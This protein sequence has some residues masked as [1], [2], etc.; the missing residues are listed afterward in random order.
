[1][2]NN[3]NSSED[4][5]A[6]STPGRD[7]VTRVLGD[8]DVGAFRLSFGQERLWFLD[9]LV[10]GSSTYNIT[11]GLRLKGSLDVAALEK[12]FSELVRRHEA[13]RTR[14]AAIDGQPL[15]VV[16]APAPW[17]LETTDLR[18]LGDAERE[19]EAQRLARVEA[20]RPFDLSQGPLLRTLL[21][22]LGP[23]EHL[24]LLAI[25]HIVSDGWSMGVLLNELAAC[26]G[27]FASGR[28]P[29][30]R[31]LPIQYADYAA[32][33]REQLDAEALER[34]L[35]YWREQ[36]DGAPVPMLPTDRAEED[37]SLS[38]LATRCVR[39]GADLTAKLRD[40]SRRERVTLFMTLLSAFTTLL[41]RYTG[42]NDILVS[43]SIADRNRPETED[44]IGVLINVLLLRT[45]LSGNPTFS[46]VLASV[47]DV[48]LGAFAHQNVPFEKVVEA[49]RL[50]RK[51][52]RLAH[53]RVSF[54]LQS[55]MAEMPR[56]PHL[57]V[58]P[59]KP[60][61]SAPAKVDLTLFAVELPGELVLS[62]EYN[63]SLFEP[64]TI[65]NMC[66]HLASLLSYVASDAGARI[67][68]IP[69]FD[70]CLAQMLAVPP[71]LIGRTAPL[72]PS[73]RD[74]YL[75]WLR[76]PQETT[77][78]VGLS[79]R[80]GDDLDPDLWEEAVRRVVAADETL[81]TRFVS[82]RGEPYQVVD[83]TLS[84][85]VIRVSAEREQSHQE[86]VDRF[87]RVPY[88]LIKGP[89]F[90]NV[91]IRDADGSF[92]ALFT[93]HH[94][95]ADGRSGRIYFERV[96]RTYEDLHRGGD[97]VAGAGTSFYDYA[98]EALASFDRPEV[99]EY[100]TD[101]TKNVVPFECH[102]L[103]TCHGPAV[104]RLEIAGSE[105][106][107]IRAFC[108]ANHL[109]VPS[110]LLG[111]YGYVLARYFEPAGDFVVY[112]VVGSRPRKHAETFGCFFHVVPI[113][114]PQSLADPPV[115]QRYVDHAGAY[116]R[117]LRRRQ[118]ISVLAQRRLVKNEQLRFHY[119]AYNFSAAHLLG[120][121][122]LLRGHE[123]FP[124][125][126][127]HFI[128]IDQG[129][130]LELIVHYAPER[131][132]DRD[133]A[134]RIV[135]VSRQLL[136][137]DAHSRIDL[138]LDH[139]RRLLAEWNSTDA[140]VPRQLPHELFEAQASR[141][142]DA[143]A[144]TDPE[145]TLSYDELNRA[146]NRLAHHLVRLGVGPETMTAICAPRGIDL[147]VGVLATFKAGGAFVPIDPEWPEQR[148][149]GIL[150]QSQPRVVLVTESSAGAI[151]PVADAPDDPRPALAV[152][153][154]VA[155]SPGPETNLAL[156]L[157][158]RN[159][160]YVIYTSGS[161]GVPKGVMLEQKGLR[162]HLF[163]KIRT[164]GL[165]DRDVVAQTASP[166]VDVSVWQ[167]L[168]VLLVGGRVCIPDAAA[169]FDPLRQLELAGSAGVTILEIVPSQLRVMVDTAVDRPSESSGLRWL[170]VNGEP[171]PPELCRR[172]FDAYPGAPLI[173]AYG[174]TE[175]SDD[176]TQFPIF[177]TPS[178]D[179][180]RMPIGY[181]LPNLSVYVLDR[182]L[183]QVPI[184]QWGDLY[185]GG[186][187][188]GRGYLHNPV[189]TA[190][191]FLPDPFSTSPVARLYRSGDIGRRL[192]DGA[193]EFLARV[194]DQVKIRGFRV[195][196]GE[197]EVALRRHPAV[198]DAVA[199][200]REDGAGGKRL[201][202]YVV[203]E[204]GQEPVPHELHAWLK[205][206][207]PDHLLPAATVM[208]PA[209][210]LTP[211]GKVNRRALPD[212]KRLIV[213]EDSYAPPRT[214]VEA[215]LAAIWCEVLGRERIGI[216]DD[217]FEFG[218]H[219]LVVIQIAS[220]IRDAFHVEIPVRAIFERPTIAALAPVVLELELE[221]QTDEQLA[222]LLQAIDE[223][224]PNA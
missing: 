129:D 163:A 194:D 198:K 157:C 42:Q 29:A 12:S 65:E 31:E 45:R 66:D 170:I 173:N 77:Y 223:A 80:F 205:Q 120:K 180:V 84:G 206:L 105:F 40:L 133:L 150:E 181:A 70:R 19:N 41:F 108:R 217:F 93:G 196:L 193:L 72:A 39:I 124:A 216:Y 9:R 8:N 25:H 78:S 109:S 186:A 208:L 137:D 20:A 71:T 154:E 74:L 162:N 37:P 101:T 99:I 11:A 218:G 209:I 132:P 183:N 201:V 16:A 35:T 60:K 151:G 174:P 204:T 43:T 4:L 127:V 56:L 139:E 168:A 15:Q 47:R 68:M 2:C 222:E 67:R 152:I 38:R 34:E 143:V 95:I 111:L 118:N 215:G 131:F 141:T 32:W 142:P 18:H 144:V 83:R 49:L 6:M 90:R 176:V 161:T 58:E 130:R 44:L 171:L 23:N 102:G 52:G 224:A 69:L 202:A 57:A 89:L 195:E 106:E 122:R 175:C 30:L 86:M 159:L 75:A 116:R 82:W 213:A 220:R 59:F 212:P 46:E 197:I 14:F 192:P 53:A 145:R 96:S 7:D 91:L 10:P 119:N 76:H 158:A 199:A 51:G 134:Q 85:E 3:G 156:R 33:Q 55:G 126:E 182:S 165:T 79:V 136:R 149:R 87:V 54:T 94:I 21:L 184:G 5:P 103:S 28:S 166:T 203:P 100:W 185:V 128:V 36:L 115:A 61:A 169:L 92:L 62:L 207:L 167:Q 135:T 148:I 172:W 114:F 112:N 97:G 178:S 110:Y 117:R 190:E 121:E 200:A 113:V 22:K 27:A 177:A 189:R 164:L 160:A 50:E 210:P 107:Q 140:D 81:R 88:D 104:S 73:Q 138:L 214:P 188:V 26:Y 98:S 64:A 146:A 63:S 48:A 219:S 179:Q 147:L 211:N 155:V 1:M 17:T 191:A 125:D 221:Q 187:G 153:A 13:L 123:S 24:L